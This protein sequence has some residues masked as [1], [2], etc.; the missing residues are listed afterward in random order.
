MSA[1]VYTCWYI[2]DGYSEPLTKT[3]REDDFPP[4]DLPE[5][6]KVGFMLNEIED[7]GEALE[8]RGPREGQPYESVLWQN[9]SWGID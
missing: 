1:P 9:K 5:Y 2:P 6:D 3:W 7:M 8:I 4:Y